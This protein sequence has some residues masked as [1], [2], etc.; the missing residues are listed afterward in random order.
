MTIRGA[1]GR[2]VRPQFKRLGG[3][4]AVRGGVGCEV[5]GRISRV[6]DKPHASVAS[7]T[8]RSPSEADQIQ[9]PSRADPH[10]RPRYCDAPPPSSQKVPWI[11]VRVVGQQLLEDWTTKSKKPRLG[12]GC[13]ATRVSGGVAS[14]SQSIG[15]GSTPAPRRSPR[16]CSGGDVGARGSPTPQPCC[17]DP[18]PAAA[19]LVG[20]IQVIH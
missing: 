4:G 3:V 10:R 16:P 9:S 1:R 14:R 5:R 15:A 13:A 2:A 19:V 20:S 7:I 8:P 6:S 18:R 11:A 12:R 17:R